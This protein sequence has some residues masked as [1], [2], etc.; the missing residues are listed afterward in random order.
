MRINSIASSNQNFKGIKLENEETKK[1]LKERMSK[2]YNPSGY[3]IVYLD[4]FDASQVTPVGEE[5]ERM[6][7]LA[8]SLDEDG[9]CYISKENDSFCVKDSKG[10]ILAQVKDGCENYRKIRTSSILNKLNT[11]LAA[12]EAFE[13]ATKR[14]NEFFGSAN[15]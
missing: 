14:I 13:K 9:D 1:V 3:S 15:N 8:N 6:V 12:K 5:L 10:T 2:I 11:Q 4:E 7:A